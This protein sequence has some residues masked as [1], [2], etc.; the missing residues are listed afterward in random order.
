MPEVVDCA[1]FVDVPRA[2]VPVEY[3]KRDL[4][5]YA[6]GI[7][8]KDHRYIYEHHADFAAFPTYPI[9]LTFKGDSPDVVSFP[10][11]AMG[12]FPLPPLEGV[13]AGLDAEK[14]IEKVA[15]IPA[16]GAKLRL[17]GGVVGVHDK[18]KGAL[19]ET[20][21]ELQGEDG[22]VYYRMLSSAF[23]VGA[24][25]FKAAGKQ[26]FENTT[27]P[28]GAPSMVV[29]VPTDPEIASLFRLSGDYNPLHIDPQMSKMMG[30]DVPIMHG[31]CNLGHTTR[32]VLDAV[33]GGDQRRFKR[34][35]MRFASPVLPGQCLQ[36]E[37]WSVSA[38]EVLFRTLVKETGK[39]CISNG[40]LLLTP[41]ASL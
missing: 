20:A 15:E 33:A 39:V 36:V 25:N 32:A 21:T 35:Q 14:I 24:K 26:H 41:A 7:G 19:V 27:P 9:C 16:E 28:E 30:F 37:I 6:L 22:K 5:L 34:V 31:L 8:S 4:M 23:L 3:N 10:S 40:S 18:G 13:R 38:T 17:V 12:S 11:P 29:E 1:K 2:S